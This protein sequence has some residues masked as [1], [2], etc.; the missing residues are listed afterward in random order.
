MPKKSLPNPKPDRSA[1]AEVRY[2]VPRKIK[3]K[4]SLPKYKTVTV[5]TSRG[6]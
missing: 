1:Y 2:K 4:T 3:G 5:K 6:R